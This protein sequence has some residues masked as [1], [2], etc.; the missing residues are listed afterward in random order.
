VWLA[1]VQRR[2]SCESNRNGWDSGWEIAHAAVSRR[3]PISLYTIV[4]RTEGYTNAVGLC[5]SLK[6]HFLSPRANFPNVNDS[7]LFHHCEAVR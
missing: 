3:P 2:Q 1:G 6:R 7:Q 4:A 5:P